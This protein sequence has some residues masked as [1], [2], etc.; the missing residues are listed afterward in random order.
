MGESFKSQA[1]YEAAL[2]VAADY[3]ES[4]W[5]SGEDLTT[6]LEK[7]ADYREV[8]PDA[9]ASPVQHLEARIEAFMRRRSNDVFLRRDDPDGIGPSLGM[10]VGHP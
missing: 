6:L 9:P 8:V 4:D 2:Q 1:E 7:I 5:A 10:D 3:V